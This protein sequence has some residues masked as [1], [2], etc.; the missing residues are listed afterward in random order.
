MADPISLTTGAIAKL[1][2]TK[3]LERA[4]GETGK[5]ITEVT[6]KKMGDLQQAIAQRF[7]GNPKGESAIALHE[8]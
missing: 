1:A 7:K 5:K 6:L 4:A 8:H 2:F 3:F